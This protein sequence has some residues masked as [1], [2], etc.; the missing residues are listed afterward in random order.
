MYAD[1]LVISRLVAL[2]TARGALLLRCHALEQSCISNVIGKYEKK[3]GITNDVSK[4]LDTFENSS[5]VHE[6]FVLGFA[7]EDFK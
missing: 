2:W 7:R 1:Y 6:V 4:R 5:V 3:T